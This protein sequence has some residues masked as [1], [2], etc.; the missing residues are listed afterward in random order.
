MYPNIIRNMKEVNYIWSA[1]DIRSTIF[2]LNFE[3]NSKSYFIAPQ[4]RLSNK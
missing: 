3:H 1:E 2:K 4:N